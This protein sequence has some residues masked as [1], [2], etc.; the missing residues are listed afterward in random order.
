MNAE[1]PERE[2]RKTA[3][4]EDLAILNDDRWVEVR[5]ALKAAEDDDGAWWDKNEIREA[6]IRANAMGIEP[7]IVLACYQA[8]SS[9]AGLVRRINSIPSRKRRVLAIDDEDAI[10]DCLQINLEATQRFEV[11]TESDPTRAISTAVEFEPDILLIDMVMPAKHGAE[12]L[13]EIRSHDALR[14][15]PAIM[16]TALADQL[17]SGGVAKDGLLFL[18]KPVST[19]KLI[20]CIEELIRV[21][22][23]PAG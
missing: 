9:H 2:I 21:G 10:L 12:L 22:S 17:D 15:T 4:Q 8:C 6:I 1:T 13:A 3:E 14:E 20:F 23:S 5:R 11:R 19:K 16:I 18:S 7:S